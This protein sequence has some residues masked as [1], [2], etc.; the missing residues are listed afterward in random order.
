MRLFSILAL[1][2]TSNAV[3]AGEAALRKPRL[4]V[5]IIVSQMR[6]D[7]LDDLAHDFSEKGFK[8]FL[9]KGVVCS[10]AS[11]NFMQTT[12]LPALSSIATGAYP[13]THGI[14][15]ERWIERTTNEIVPITYDK[16]ID[17][18]G[19]DYGL[20]K[21]SSHN[22]VCQTLGDKLIKSNPKSKAVT[23]AIDAN[24]AIVLG[25][26]KT[27]NYWMDL[28]RGTWISSSKFMTEL[29]QWAEDY[30]RQRNSKDFINFDW[31]SKTSIKTPRNMMPDYSK[32]PENEAGNTITLEFAKQALIYEHLGKD[33]NTDLLNICLDSPRYISSKYGYDAEQTRQMFIRLDQEIGEFVNYLVTQLSEQDIL[34]VLSS[35]H[36][37]SDT[38]KDEN[39]RFDAA[40]FK[41]LAN[42]FLSSQ[43]G[44]G[45]WVVDYIDR[46][47]FLNHNL[48]YSNRLSLE[49]VQNSLA[50]F[51][52]QFRGVA[53]V[54]TSSNLQA[55]YFGA[56]VGSLIQNG[57]YPKRSGDVTLNFQP[58]W[59]H[60]QANTLSESGSLY[61]YDRE[62]PLIFMGAG[63]K[64]NTIRSPVDMCALAPTLAYI[65][66]INPPEGSTGVRIDDITKNFDIK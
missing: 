32:I 45:E 5:N 18:V 19:C 16:D 42:S 64:A 57:F 51:A 52:L 36:G 41:I 27:Q 65:M 2:I 37:A 63:L 47:L 9:K 58:G 54:Y 59:I 35:D 49:Q 3:F 43:F 66:Q 30:N 38:Q 15:T 48:I 60:A 29:P 21:Y 23:I 12:T 28:K 34:F 1:L 14:V 17:G 53:N 39:K 8:E 55:N 31:R 20:G 25:G 26:E 62:V 6:S 50:S 61:N 40:K 11:F 13:S 56:G 4:V 10:Q 7:V 46:Q 44:S 33:D 24:S 22:L